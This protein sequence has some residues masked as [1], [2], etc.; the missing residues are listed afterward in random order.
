MDRRTLLKQSLM[1]ATFGT[2]G[3]SLQSAAQASEPVLARSR[4]GYVGAESSE[5]WGELSQDYRLCSTGVGQSP[6]DLKA[7]VKAEL[8]NLDFSY[9]PSPLKILHNGHTVQVNYAPGSTLKL[10]GQTYDL[11]QLHFHAPSEHTVEQQSYAMEMHLVHQH[12]QTKQFAVVGVFIKT[13]AAHQGLTPIWEHMPSQAAPEVAISD[14]SIN[15]SHL[16][17]PEMTHFYRYHGSL[18]TPPCSEVV[19]WIVL[20]QPIEASQQQID[21]F[22]AAVGDNARP[23]QP[24]NQRR[25]FFR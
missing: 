15:A 2:A 20:G 9:Q 19:N 23:V 10:D 16:L 11:L 13:G 8:D 4:W 21:R 14:I 25:L 24:L 5:H 18:T 1:V 17:P 7:S 6:V 22:I 3:I 12:P